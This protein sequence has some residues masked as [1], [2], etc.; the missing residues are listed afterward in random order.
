MDVPAPS[1][2]NNMRILLS[3][4]H[5]YPAFADVGAGPHPQPYPSGSGFWIHDLLARGLAE[6]GHQVFYLLRQGAA[7]PLPPGVRAVSQPVW[8]ADILHTISDRDDA[9]VSEWQSRGRGSRR[10]T[11]TCER[12]VWPNDQ[13]P[14]IGS[15]CR[16]R[17]RTG[18]ADNVSS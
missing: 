6:L 1:S 10:A 13:R 14:T 16:A 9:L 5:R 7:K 12:A 11:S 18:T 3:S 2:A 17:S 8:D 15:S 4:E